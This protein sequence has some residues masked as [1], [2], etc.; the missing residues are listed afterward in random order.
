MDHALVAIKRLCQ[1]GQVVFTAKAE[2]E[3]IRDGLE[4]QDVI[5]A[6]LNASSITKRLRSH[7]PMTGVRETL[8]VIDSATWDGRP[9]YT[10]GKLAARD[11]P[12]RFYVLVSS[13]RS[14]LP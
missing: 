13:Q 4:R 10:K 6:I 5:E 14:V 1:A 9:V 3:M 7:N 11:I 2:A 8:Y 12:A